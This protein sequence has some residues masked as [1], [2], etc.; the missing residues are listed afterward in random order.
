ML[1]KNC[2][3]RSKEIRRRKTAPGC[4]ILDMALSAVI[5]AQPDPYRVARR[6]RAVLRVSGLTLR[7]YA[8]LH[9]KTRGC[10]VR[11]LM[12][13]TS[14]GRSTVNAELAAGYNRLGV[15]GF[16]AAAAVMRYSAFMLDD[17]PHRTLDRE[18][19]LIR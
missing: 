17:I 12:E 10:A 18:L 11:D 9:L 13:Q 4:I 6:V 7:Q 19:G 8:L 5:Q 3:E 14:L 1:K 15:R 16:K 2:G